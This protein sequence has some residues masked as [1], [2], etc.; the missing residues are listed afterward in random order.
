[1]SSARIF[2][3]LFKLHETGAR[4]DFRDVHERLP[5]KEQQLLAEIVLA[6]EIHEATLERGL[7]FVA[8]LA[9]S[10]R[11]AE[12]KRLKSQIQQ[13]E[14]AGNLAGALQLAEELL[15]VERNR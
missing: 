11:Q 8:A 10:G 2:E 9:S 14:R 3:T 15:R 1:M 5:E 13:A 4:I 6:D 7:E 12:L